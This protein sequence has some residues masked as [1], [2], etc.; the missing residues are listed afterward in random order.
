MV[1]LNKKRAAAAA[2]SDLLK[3]VF[4]VELAQALRAARM[5]AGKS[6]A[7]IAAILGI[8]RTQYIR[9]ESG[10]R[11][12]PVHHLFALADLYGLTLDELVGRSMSLF[13]RF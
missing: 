8:Q 2:R 7:E 4:I 12:I 1:I 11:E 10:E 13:W 5:R 6:Q 3:G 9:Y